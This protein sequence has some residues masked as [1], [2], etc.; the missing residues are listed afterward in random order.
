MNNRETL[1]PI[2]E[3]AG[4]GGHHVAGQALVDCLQRTQPEVMTL[5]NLSQWLQIPVNTLRADLRRRPESMPR[6]L[7]L[8]GRRLVRFLRADVAA[9]LLA[10]TANGGVEVDAGNGVSAD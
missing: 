6:R 8:P 2:A 4:T 3:A 7:N 5:E 9:W 10:S 1:V